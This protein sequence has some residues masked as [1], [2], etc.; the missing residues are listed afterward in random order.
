MDDEPGL[1]VQLQ[2]RVADW[3]MRVAPRIRDEQAI[4]KME[5]VLQFPQEEDDGELY[6]S[7]E[8]T[9]TTVPEDCGGRVPGMRFERDEV[10]KP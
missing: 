6:L 4:A 5:I 8:T 10:T 2:R 9:E 3:V 1:V 7:C